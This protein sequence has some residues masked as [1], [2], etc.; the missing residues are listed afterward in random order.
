MWKNELIHQMLT[1][2]RYGQAIG[3]VMSYQFVMGK[4]PAIDRNDLV[5]EFH[6]GVAMALKEVRLDIGDPMEYLIA[7]GV[8]W[9]KR[10]VRKECNHTFIE[11]CIICGKVRPYRQEPC[12]TCGGIDF[13]IS[14]RFV[15]FDEGANGEVFLPTD[16]GL[17]PSG[18]LAV[19]NRRWRLKEPVAM[20]DIVD[21]GE[22]K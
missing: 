16:S 9:V 1:S 18:R 14:P 15:P 8:L 19:Q 12:Y 13:L 7:R 2:P 17:L 6:R 20:D 22:G 4:N 10:V 21:A 11:E 5:G 3:K